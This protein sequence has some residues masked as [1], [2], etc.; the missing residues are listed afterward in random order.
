MNEL[1]L[2]CDFNTATSSYVD[3]LYSLTV[4][5][6]DDETMNLPDGE[7]VTWVTTP[8]YVSKNVKIRAE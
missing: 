1:T 7:K 3:V 5:S 8:V 6:R 2:L 4:L